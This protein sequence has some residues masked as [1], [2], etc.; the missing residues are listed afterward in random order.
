MSSKYLKTAGIV[1]ILCFAG[2]A[3]IYFLVI[4]P[5]S[6]QIERLK[7]DHEQW[8]QKADYVKHGTQ[9]STIEQIQEQIED[10]QNKLSDFTVSSEDDIQTLAYVEIYNIS[11]E[12]GLEINI[13]DPST[14]G[15][16]AAFNDCKYIYGQPIEVRFNAS[17]QEFAV[18]L[19]LL[20]RHKTVIFIDNFSISKTEQANKH[21]VK[22]Q[23][24]VLVQNEALSADKNIKVAGKN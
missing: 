11:K 13:D 14:K 22:M 8:Q 10:F 16:V 15:K 20:E 12:M 9:E 18:F 23:L 19:N 17:F 1:W 3:A 2:F 24:A 6:K 7:I 21:S 5:Q 4:L